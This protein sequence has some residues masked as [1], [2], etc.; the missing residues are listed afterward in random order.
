MLNSINTELLEAGIDEAGRGC[1]LGPVHTAAVILPKEFDT[2][3]YLN[4]RDSKKLTPARRNKLRKYIESVAIAWAVDEGPREEID[5]YN[6]LQATLISMH[7]AVEKLS[8]TPEHLAVDGNHFISSHSFL[9]T[10]NDDEIIPYTLVTGGD[11][12]YR[13]IAAASILAKTHHDEFIEKLLIKNPDLNKYGLSTN[14]GYGT[15]IHMDGIRKYGISE[16]HRLSFKPCQ[17]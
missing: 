10:N 15:R 5:K 13:N 12:K 3:E 16:F 2:D 6:I 11:D 1:L 14:K 9:P 8:T 7:R 4:I 17:L